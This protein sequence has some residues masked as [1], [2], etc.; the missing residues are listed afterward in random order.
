MIA[1]GKKMKMDTLFMKYA[2]KG[3]GFE[4]FAR[5]V[6]VHDVKRML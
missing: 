1:D 6:F 4:T 2:E 5:Q 3:W